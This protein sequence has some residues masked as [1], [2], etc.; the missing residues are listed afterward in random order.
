MVDIVY[1][2]M[3]RVCYSLYEVCV[4]TRVLTK[5]VTLYSLSVLVDIVY[6]S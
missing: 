5:Q 3:G 4:L 2:S 6:M 1:M